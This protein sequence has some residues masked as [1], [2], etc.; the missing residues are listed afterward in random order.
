MRFKT[1]AVITSL[2]FIAAGVLFILQGWRVTYLLMPPLP[3]LT[4]SQ[5]TSIRA[6]WMKW[7][8]T[9]LPFVYLFG[10]MLIGSGLLVRL[11]R[12]IR[13]TTVQMNVS[14][15]LLAMNVFLGVLGVKGFGYNHPKFAAVFASL[16]LTQAVAYCWLLLKKPKPEAEILTATVDPVLNASAESWK[17]QIHEAAAQQERNRLAREL[18]DSIKQQLFSIN[19]NAATVQARWENDQVGAKS[20]LEAVRGSVR[21][22]MAEMETMLHNL[23]PAP[24]EAVGLV[25]AVRQQCESLQYRT[26]ANVTAEI[27]EL[28]TNQEFP[29]GAQDAV[30]RIAQEALTNIARHARATNVRVRLHRQTR[31]DGDALWLKVEDDGSGFDA[32]QAAGMGLSNI[33]SRVLEIGGSLQLSAR[34][35]EGTSLKV[36]VPLAANGSRDVKRDLR[37]AMVFAVVG[38]LSGGFG[39]ILFHVGHWPWIGLPAFLLSAFC[40]YRAAQSIERLKDSAAITPPGALD[41]KLQLHLARATGVAAFMWSTVNWLILEMYWRTFTRQV[42]YPILLF[43]L[44]WQIYEVWRIHQI[45]K[46]QHGAFTASDSL[47]SLNKVWRHISLFLLAVVVFLLDMPLFVEYFVFRSAAVILFLYW[48]FLTG[49]RWRVKRKIA[50]GQ[51]GGTL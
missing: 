36:R 44:L 28:P 11:I 40:C 30:F 6:E 25:E 18:H 32:S 5:V 7:R 26:G 37:I 17:Q 45:L 31:G 49:W 47:L 39:T 21:E 43:W 14:M 20:A 22:A 1:M 8:F 4:S 12:N 48:L 23:R 19:V 10:A 2:I 38:F 29:P 13:D 33:R 35:G 51:V 27:G 50:T 9:M 46:L 3:D 24:L 42:R 16:F 41:L 34:E 15:A